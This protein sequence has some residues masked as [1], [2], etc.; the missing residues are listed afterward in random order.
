MP[1]TWTPAL[2]PIHL[3]PDVTQI[4]H[5]RKTSVP[6][7]IKH[8]LKVY[9]DAQ[10]KSTTFSAGLKYYHMYRYYISQRKFWLSRI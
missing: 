7:G 2:A 5:C 9:I 6:L 4:P 1:Y 10:K 8:F 3:H